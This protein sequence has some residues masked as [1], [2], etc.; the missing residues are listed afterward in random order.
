MLVISPFG[1]YTINSASL[2]AIL[3]PIH[4]TLSSPI[5]IK[6]LAKTTATTV[7]SVTSHQR[8]YQRPELFRD[9][10]NTAWW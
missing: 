9:R 10:E 2:L 7:T 3:Q 4:F 1:W 8:T 5:R 6:K